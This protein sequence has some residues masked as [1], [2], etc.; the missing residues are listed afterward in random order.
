M[1]ASSII[2]K[3]PCPHCIRKYINQ[4]EL[5]KHIKDHKMKANIKT[6]E[7]IMTSEELK[8]AL[9]KAYEQGYQDAKD[10]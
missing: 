9:E 1:K 4:E 6:G 5:T 3:Y 10:K 2:Y 8:E 7:I